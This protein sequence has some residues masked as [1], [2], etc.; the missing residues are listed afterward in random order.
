MSGSE[1]KGKPKGC[2]DE[3]NAF[4]R[5]FQR[6]LAADRTCG[7]DAH[8]QPCFC[9][10]RYVYTQFRSDDDEVFYEA[11]VCTETLTSWRLP[12]NRWL[13]R[14]TRSGELDRGEFHTRLSLSD[15]MPR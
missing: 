4:D 2:E 3:S 8:Q 12:D 5:D 13:V 11:P 7:Y 1:Y 14:Y 6:P 10:F 15:T 9:A